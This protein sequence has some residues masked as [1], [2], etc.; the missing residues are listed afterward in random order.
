M[1]HNYEFTSIINENSNKQ[2]SIEIQIY[3][4][5]EAIQAVLKTSKPTNLSN[6]ELKSGSKV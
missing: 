1:N 6:F 4:N 5:S 2:K 3:V